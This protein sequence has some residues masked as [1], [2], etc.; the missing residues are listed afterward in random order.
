M[1]KSQQENLQELLNK[2]QYSQIVS[3]TTQFTVADSSDYQ[4]M[5]LTGQAYEGLLKYREAYRYYQHCLTIDSTQTELLYTAARVAANL[6]MAN[7]AE[8]Y[9]LTIWASDTT[10]F[11]ANYQLARFYA[12]IGNDEKAIERYEYLL[13]QDPENPALLRAVGDCYYRLEDTY[14]AFYAYY[15]AF[16]Y[17]KENAGLASTVVN[18]MLPLIFLADRIEMALE[19]CDTALYYNPGNWQL[20][21][22]Q[23]TVFFTAKR[24]AEA[25]SVFSMLLAQ[26]DS[27]Y[28]NLKYGGFSRYY[29]AQ[30]MNAVD[31][32]EKAYQEDDKAADVC[33]FL[34]SVLGRTGE[35]KRAYELFD[36]VEE[37]MKPNPAYVNLLMEFRGSTY[38]RDGRY[39]EASALFYPLWENS[40]RSDLLSNIWYCYANKEVSK[41]SN[42]DERARSMFVNVLFATELVARK[43]DNQTNPAT[44]NNVR[45]QLEQFRQE[46]FFRSITEHPMI[47]PDN[48]KSTITTERLLELIQ[49]L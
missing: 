16:E 14:S 6:G 48:K 34:G 8:T 49:K 44:V 4:T 19:V 24:Y 33:L 2:K 22:N 43:N 17:N 39:R 9:F 35:R 38:Y 3:Y 18:T 25:D 41:L 26:G 37:L 47:A 27:A 13:E 36:Q 29:A 32:L 12:Q 20:L 15:E 31:P 46:M 28:Y 7:D 42:D 1:I 45:S 23:G 40:K 21:Q 10:D 5:Y 30:Y 11:Y